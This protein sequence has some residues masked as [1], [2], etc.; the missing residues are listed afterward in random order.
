MKKIWRE[1][2]LGFAVGTGM[3]AAIVLVY[4]K[5]IHV[6][7][8][9]VAL[10]FLLGILYVS[11]TWGLTVSIYMSALAALA[12]N[13]FFLP[14]FG[15]LTIADPQNWV[16]LGAFLVTA[17]TASRLAEAARGEA[18]DAN[19]RRREVERLYAFTQQ[20]LVAGNMGELLNSI[21]RRMVESFELQDA[22]LFLA[23]T[24]EVYRFAGDVRAL[25]SDRLKAVMARGEPV[26]EAEKKL[27][28]MPV[29]MGVRT[30]GSLGISGN[31]VSR[32]T[33]EAV[34]TLIAIA[35]AR[36]SALEALGRAEAARE[37][38]KL[39]TALLDSVTHELR[40]PLT[41]IKGAI[42]SLLTQPELTSAHR[43]ELMAVIDEESNRLN[44]LIEEALEMA[45]LDAGDIEL[46]REPTPIATVI[47]AAR[48]AMKGPLAQHRVE[49]RLAPQLQEVALDFE[50]VKEVLAHLLE[51]AAKYSPPGAPITISSEATNGYL[52][53]SV[54][55]RGPGIET[56]EQSLIFDKFYR[57]KDQR[58]RVQGTG[59]GLAICKAIVEAHGGKIGVTSQ[60]GSG[61]VFQFS[62]PLALPAAETGRP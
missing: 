31:L 8:T 15:T 42:T 34:G 60:V 54:A 58:Y 25:D 1:Q 30:V 46:K 52:V 39:R 50:R 35:V 51:N 49:A 17:I 33:L 36:F 7:P 12:F 37:E 62:L 59:M 6:N 55:D 43:C 40:T 53:T 11:A 28:F 56:I 44:R 4:T 57:G 45:R 23:S 24:N 2:G 13:Y 3:M 10:S 21:P 61:S 32:Q 22:A 16:A 19:R 38:D 20:L 18:R 9:T 48:E 41:G 47:E 26:V 14:P 5:L 27:S 29:R